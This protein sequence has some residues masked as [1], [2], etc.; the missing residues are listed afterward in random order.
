MALVSYH[1]MVVISFGEIRT[2]WTVY[3]SHLNTYNIKHCHFQFT[4]HSPSIASYIIQLPLE[5]YPFIL[6]LANAIVRRV[7]SCNLVTQWSGVQASWNVTP[8]KLSGS[9]LLGIDSGSAVCLTL[10]TDKAHPALFRN[11]L[12]GLGAGANVVPMYCGPELRMIG[13]NFGTE[14]GRM[15]ER[16]YDTSQCVSNQNNAQVSFL[17]LT[18]TKK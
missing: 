3:V 14:C 4:R 9:K 8:S 2:M 17:L 1:A 5:H 18:W 13:Q 11:L 12:K 7:Y 15:Q 10:L 16:C 6:Y